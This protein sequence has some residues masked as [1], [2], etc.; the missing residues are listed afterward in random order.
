MKAAVYG[1][2]DGIV[3]TFAVVAGS[4]G[5]QLSPKIVLTLGIANLV[6]D[7]LSMGIGDFL[8]ERSEQQLRKQQQ[9]AYETTGLWK[10]GLTTFVAFLCAGSL[11]LIP[12]VFELFTGLTIRGNQFWWSFAATGS[13]LFMVG[14]V[15]SIFTKGSWWRSGVE[16]LSIGAVAAVSAYGIGA[17]IESLV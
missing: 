6:A 14:A 1:A 9:K 5:A 12:Y 2:N 4:A 8:G 7:G 10:T 17:L 3:T 13:A 11:P 15:R 16:M